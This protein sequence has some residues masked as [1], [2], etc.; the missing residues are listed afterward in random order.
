[1]TK[2]V[3]TV[4]KWA[5]S[6]GPFRIR[7]P[8]GECTL[9]KDV[10]LDTLACDLSDIPVKLVMHD[11][12]NQWWKPLLKGGW[13]PPI[14]MVG[15]KVISQGEALNRGI[16]TQAVIESHVQYTELVG[17]HIFGKEDCPHCKRASQLMEQAGIHFQYHDVIRDARALYEMLGRVKPII[18]PKTPVTVPQIWIDG[19]YIGGA[20]ELAHIVRSTDYIKSGAE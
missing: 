1:M 12:L 15:D 6:W 2:V 5:G 18:G 14:V 19:K 9:T 3:I 4:Y 10:I 13:H 8:C 20:D 16:L 11:W 17:N 7:V